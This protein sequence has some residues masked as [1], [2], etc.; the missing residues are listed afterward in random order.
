MVVVER[1]QFA[2]EQIK[3]ALAQLQ[4]ILESPFFRSSQ[5]CSRLLQYS[6]ERVLAG[7]SHEDLKERIIGVEVFRR[8]ANY[9]TSQDSIVRVTANEVRKRLAQYYGTAGADKPV[10]ELAAGSYAVTFRWKDSGTAHTPSPVALANASSAENAGA[11]P[12]SAAT[13][14]RRR[15]MTVWLSLAIIAALTVFVAAIVYARRSANASPESGIWQTLLDSRKPVTICVAQPVAYRPWSGADALNGPSDH[16]VSLPNAF[17]GVGDAYALANVTSFLSSHGKAW[18]LLP[19]SD[20]SFRDLAAGPTILIGAFSNPWTEKLTENLRFV[21]VQGPP[22][23]LIDRS[24]A[25]AGW[26]IPVSPQWTS[27]EDYAV[28]SRF[29]SPDTGE[30]IIS[31][32]GAANFGTEAAGKFLTDPDRLAA[33]FRNAPKNWRNKNFQIVLHVNVAG[34]APEQPAVVAQYFW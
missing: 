32:A 15:H 26:T 7:C 31:L 9:D 34:N 2:E 18:S 3:Q 20:T 8:E 10:I 5:R 30:T 13:S 16:M 33:A 25:G 12:A 21:F 24:R 22:N 11:V 19:S 14:G 17:I 23:R 27:P 6:V 1:T 29:R 28:I 4:R